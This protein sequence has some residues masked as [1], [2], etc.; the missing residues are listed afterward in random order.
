MK[1]S[2]SEI[3]LKFI[4][5]WEGR[6]SRVYL[7]SGGAPS[8]GIGHLLTKSERQ[9]GKITI[10]SK[11]GTEIVRYSNGLNDQQINNLLTQDL[12]KPEKVVNDKVTVTLSQY[13]YDALVI[14]TF[15]VGTTAFSE[16]T[17]LKIL[18]KGLLLEVVPQFRRWIYDNGAQVKGLKNRREAE[19]LLWNNQWRL[20]HND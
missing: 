10:T 5:D 3:G 15:N 17:L 12:A 20:Q 13:Q 2:I 16:S 9:S 8:I 1:R 18:N 6:K 14:F 19:I 7:D 11:L 4:E